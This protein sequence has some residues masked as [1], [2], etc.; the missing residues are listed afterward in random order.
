[1]HRQIIMAALLLA[2]SAVALAIPPYSPPS[3][4]DDS[5]SSVKFSGGLGVGVMYGGL[6]TNVEYRATDQ[7]SL[8]AGLGLDGH[9]QWLAG[10]RYY[11]KPA[12]HGARGRFTLGVGEIARDKDIIPDGH[13]S[14][15]KGVLGIGWSWAN[16]DHDFRGWD[17]DIT[18]EGRISLGYHF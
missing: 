17:I 7:V 9:G 2:L 4:S 14:M 11:F 16:A 1:M 3:L 6:G 12:G 8:T 18:T 5:G 13:D 10:A 15:M